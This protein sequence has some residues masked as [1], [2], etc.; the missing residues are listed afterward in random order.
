MKPDTTDQVLDLLDATYASAALAAA[1]ELDLFGHLDREP[2]SAESISGRLEIPLQRCRYWLQLLER[3][4]LLVIE[5]GTYRPSAA[6]R[7]A[8]NEAYDPASW[9]HLAREA[10]EAAPWVRD[11]SHTL[12]QPG[13]AGDRLGL[14]RGD[15][16]AEMADD[17]DQARAFTRMLRDFH[18]AMADELAPLIDMTGVDRMMDLGG[19]SG[20]FSLALLRRHQDLRSVVVDIPPVCRAA[21]ELAESREEWG[22]LEWYGADFLRDPLPGCFDLI[23]E[24]DVDVYGTELFGKLRA[25]LNPGGRLV[26]VDQLAPDTGSAPSARAH[27][28]LRLSLDDPDFRF[29]TADDLEEQ[30]R[31]AGFGTVTRRHLTFTT[32]PARRFTDGMVLIEAR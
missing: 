14:A 3:T 17:A 23:L 6:A 15:Y 31:A 16:F 18:Q 22:R 26:I 27:W 7:T 20:G 4:G 10:R 2:L 8:I 30:L 12:R 5:A 24:C 32:G 1:L 13:S 9:A 29:P 21:G 28:A 11:L 25:A 19:G